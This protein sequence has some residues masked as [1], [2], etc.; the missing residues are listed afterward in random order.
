MVYS[1]KYEKHFY[2]CAVELDF[3]ALQFKCR[4]NEKDVQ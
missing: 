3:D 4:D 1:T 2:F